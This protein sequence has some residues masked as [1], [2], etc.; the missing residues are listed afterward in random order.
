MFGDVRMVH[1]VHQT[2]LILEIFQHTS[3]ESTLIN[4]FDGHLELG[5]LLVRAQI[6]FTEGALAEAF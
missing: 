4:D 2:D 5:I 3:V 6:Y 1:R